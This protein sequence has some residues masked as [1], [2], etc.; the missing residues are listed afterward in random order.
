[1]HGSL[2]QVMA[3]LQCV[4]NSNVAVTKP[5]VLVNQKPTEISVKF[6][7]LEPGFRGRPTHLSYCQPYSVLS[8]IELAVGILKFSFR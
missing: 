6:Q 1:M 4:Y 2:T 5:E 8:D 7:R 3:V